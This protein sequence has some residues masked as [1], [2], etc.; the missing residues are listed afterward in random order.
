VHFPD[1]N[2]FKKKMAEGNVIPV[3]RELPADLETPVSAFLK[4]RTDQPAFLLE[5]AEEGRRTGRYSF[6]AC[7]A[8]Q[9]LTAQGDKAVLRQNGMQQEICLGKRDALHVLEEMMSG[10]RSI[11]NEDLPSFVGGAVG[12]LA[13]DMVGF[14]ERLPD[15][16]SDELNLPDCAFI[17]T[18][19]MV[20]FDHLHHTM[21]VVSTIP[22]TESPEQAY[23]EAVAGIDAVVRALE[24]PLPPP[25]IARCSPEN[26]DMVSGV[27][28]DEFC[29][30][31]EVAREYIAAG[32]A[33]QIVLSRRLRRSTT[34]DG[35]G[36]YR[37]LRRLNPSPYMF[38]LDMGGFQ[39]IGSSPEVLVKLEGQKASIRPLAGTR[40]RGA[41]SA[42]DEALVEELLADEKE[43][44]EHVML[45]DLARND[46]GRV[47]R[48]STVRVPILM[49]VEK[50][51]HVMHIV[52][53]VQGNICDGKNAFDVLRACFPAG[54]VSGAPKIRAMEII[55]ELEG[56]RRGPYAGAVGYFGFSGD[57]D[58]CI[59]IR[60][61]VKIG[62]TVHLQAGAGIV[63]DSE[64]A[65]EHEEVMNKL[66]ALE[67]AVRNAEGRP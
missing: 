29:H 39:L 17:L 10:Y 58:T 49:D 7:S 56:L 45:V 37:A 35:F 61:I 42:E 62:E 47:C 46:L 4:L 8:R 18:D 12:Y 26:G 9:L 19:M 27:T 65:R 59:T 63:F 22:I 48:A 51:S 38:Y 31:V 67:Q 33:F 6:L 34:A 16:A 40:R 54:T 2:T 20:I 5:S 21:K 28:V 41:N 13:Y 52:S 50:Y 14:F 11:R 3:Y 44:A 24:S 66:R 55:A 15:V 32:D 60:T 23:D 43:R 1:F 64:P 53:E 30:K 57:M 36:I 25:E